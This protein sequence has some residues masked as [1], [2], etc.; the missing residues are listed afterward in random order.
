MQR[1]A[2]NGWQTT[3]D[4]A[5]VL[6]SRGANVSRAE[7]LRLTSF[8]VEEERPLRLVSTIV[9]SRSV[10]DRR[11]RPEVGA[12]TARSAV[13]PDCGTDS[14]RPAPHPSVRSYDKN[15][16]PKVVEVVLD[17]SAGT[18]G[19]LEYVIDGVAQGV[20]FR[21]LQGKELRLLASTNA[22]CKLELISYEQ[23]AAG[24]R[25]ISVVGARCGQYGRTWVR[26]W[27]RSI[28]RGTL[29][30]HVTFEHARG[31]DHARRIA[32]L[33]VRDPLD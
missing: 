33:A 20:A 25:A 23:R 3:P 31:V 1:E 9:S 6:F 29:A 7:Q 14:P 5:A 12:H 30:I 18:D 21:G 4:E 26:V 8:R 27:R 28:M 15:K 22:D 13:L 10:F 17:L 11:T 32:R 24:V 2:S 16:Y 19:T